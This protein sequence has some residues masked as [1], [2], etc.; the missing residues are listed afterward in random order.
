MAVTEISGSESFVH[1]STDAGL[2]TFVC[3]VEGVHAFEPGD[4][5]EARG[6][7]ARAF[8]FGPAGLRAVAPA[9]PAPARETVPA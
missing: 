6:D 1:V 5:V 9:A 2:G 8:A 4:R 3:L 7:L